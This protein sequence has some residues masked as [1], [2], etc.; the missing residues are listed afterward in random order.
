M[1]PSFGRIQDISVGDFD[2]TISI[3]LTVFDPH[4]Q[5]TPI[6]S[7]IVKREYIPGKFEPVFFNGKKTDSNERM[8]TTFKS[9][10]YNFNYKI[11][12]IAGTVA[13]TIVNYSIDYISQG[14]IFGLIKF[15]SRVDIIIPNNIVKLN[16]KKGDYTEGGEILGWIN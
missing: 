8:V 12:Q 15:G 11:I 1:S 6:E 13:R 7:T 5:Y 3:I 4:I 10:N 14:E 16:L 9:V 2:T